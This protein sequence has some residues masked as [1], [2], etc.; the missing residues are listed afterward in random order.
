MAPAAADAA[1]D[2]LVREI[3]QAEA[4]IT[5]SVSLS[6]AE[7]E[8]LH[9]RLVA[10]ERTAATL[11]RARQ[12]FLSVVSHELRTP[13]TSILGFLE[14]ILSGAVVTREDEHECLEGALASAHD[15]HRVVNDILEMAELEAGDVNFRNEQVDLM[16][17]LRSELAPHAAAAMEKGL[18]VVLEEPAV[19][20]PPILADSRKLRTV[21]RHLL[22]NAVKFTPAGGIRVRATMSPEP[23]MLTVEIADTGIGFSPEMA[24]TLAE[25]FLQAEHA[26]TRSRGGM[27]LGLTVAMRLL[28]GMGGR[29]ELRSEGHGR[30]AVASFTLPLVPALDVGDFAAELAIASH[31]A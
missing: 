18:H 15:L 5:A 17:V 12:D 31:R 20:L 9:G 22:S 13:L 29:L 3:R 6:P 1:G 2:S 26:I 27:G 8:M 7:R 19:P 28:H 25:A 14:I 21:T 4:A 30:G 10:L 16:D 11:L 23:E 24:G